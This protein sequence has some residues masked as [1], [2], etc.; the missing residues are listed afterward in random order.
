MVEE[1]N[2]KKNEILDCKQLA[3]YALKT[4]CSDII[5]DHMIR[6]QTG[7]I[8]ATSK[9][10]EINFTT[11][12]GD[13]KKFLQRYETHVK[14]CLEDRKLTK[15]NQKRLEQNLQQMKI[16]LTKKQQ[17]VDDFEKN[18]DWKQLT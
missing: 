10:M 11:K 3:T 8:D 5:T 17:Q 9:E 6:I 2:T 4:Q 7:V 18:I 14:A 1:A 16:N 15:E 13:L 12:F